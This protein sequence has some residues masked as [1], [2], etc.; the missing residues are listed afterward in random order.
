MNAS[1]SPRRLLITTD[2]VGGVWSYTLDL[3]RALSE[4]KVEVELAILGPAAAPAQ[5]AS[6]AAI[7][8]AT[9]HDTALPLDWM[10]EDAATLESTA[11]L[12][13]TLAWEREV[14]LVQVHT[15]ALVGSSAWPAPVLAVAHSCVGTWW[16]AVRDTPLPEA[17]HARRDAMAAGLDAADGVVAPTHAFAAALRQ[18]YG[19]RR[20]I[21]VVH[22]GRLASARSERARRGVLCA[23]RLWDEGK[24]IA[25]LDRVAGLTP[26][27]PFQ[28]AGPTQG[29]N[30]AAVELRRMEMLGTLSETGMAEAMGA[31]RIF[32]S[33]ALYEP[34]G[35]AV[36]EAAQA[37]LP[38][39]LAD[40]PTLRELWDG[41]AIF[42]LPH[43]ESAWAATLDALHGDDAG[44][45]L[46]GER[47]QRRACTYTVERLAAAMWDKYRLMIATSAADRVD[48]A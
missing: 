20:D 15:P 18:V 41:A 40:I 1:R 32:A 11:A 17:F 34:F 8:G 31:A 25:F 43:D 9:V 24:N 14:D 47:A 5:M 28:A 26:S 21:A 4:R 3:A 39:V 10:T 23:G 48:V 37:G 46:W 36:L 16:N 22:N 27:V 42:L 13:A 19:T 35:L 6:A 33:P 12:L 2:A 44:C 7:A 38:L 29:A 45:R 30:G